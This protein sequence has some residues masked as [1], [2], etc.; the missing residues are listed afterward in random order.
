[1]Q[2]ILSDGIN[3]I[4]VKCKVGDSNVEAISKVG[5]NRIRVKCKAAS[6]PD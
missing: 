6:V 3:R 5:I 1:M 2:N 4:R